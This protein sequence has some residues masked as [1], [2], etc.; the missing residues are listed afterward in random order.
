MCLVFCFCFCFVWF[1][2]CLFIFV[3]SVHLAIAR[4]NLARGGPDLHPISALAEESHQ[5]LSTCHICPAHGVR[6][7]SKDSIRRGISTFINQ[8]CSG[9]D[10][11][12]A[13]VHSLLSLGSSLQ[14]PAG[15]QRGEQV[16]PPPGAAALEE[17]CFLR[18]MGTS[19]DGGKN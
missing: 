13:R 2:L 15:E 4:V 6:I 16:Q 12:R 18:E 9:R 7:D 8:Y 17:G 10:C 5:T 11:M 19:R 3:R 1:V 14:Q